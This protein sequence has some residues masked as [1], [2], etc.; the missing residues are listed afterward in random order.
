MMHSFRQL[1]TAPFFA[2]LCLSVST[3]GG[4]AESAETSVS[5]VT[6]RADDETIVFSADFS[7][8]GLPCEI[9]PMH[10]T[11]WS[12]EDGVLVGQPATAEQQHKNNN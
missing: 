1:K 3:L 11:R 4:L 9:S 6:G 2:G 5:D 8:N 7:G 10:G 12:V